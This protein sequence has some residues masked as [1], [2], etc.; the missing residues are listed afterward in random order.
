MSKQYHTR[1]VDLP[2]TVRGFVSKDVDGE[3]IIFLNARLSR[4]Q[5]RITYNHEVE[6]IKKGDLDNSNYIEY[7][8]VV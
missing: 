2:P 6:H 7:N 1:L 8:D 4:E 5:N 3:P